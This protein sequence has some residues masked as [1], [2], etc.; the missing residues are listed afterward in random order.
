[1]GCQI[2]ADSKK[3]FV[4]KLFK[5]SENLRRIGSESDIGVDNDQVVEVDEDLVIEGKQVVD[6]VVVFRRKRYLEICQR[7][8]KET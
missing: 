1:M 6:G 7:W 8:S 3:I 4:R 2:I 5:L